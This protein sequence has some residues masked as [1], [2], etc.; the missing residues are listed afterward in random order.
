MKKLII[1][2]IIQVLFFGK[3]FGQEKLKNIRIIDTVKFTGVLIYDNKY[4]KIVIKKFGKVNKF[5]RK[6]EIEKEFKKAEYLFF[7]PFA[8]KRLFKRQNNQTFQFCV[9]K[10]SEN[11]LI[12]REKLLFDR[13]YVI[14]F[15]DNYFINILIDGKKFIT[16]KCL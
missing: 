8:L 3:I 2:S 7:D 6:T 9:D 15:K 14:P 5:A 12:D 16:L 10:S 1:I 13:Y 11:F 4:K